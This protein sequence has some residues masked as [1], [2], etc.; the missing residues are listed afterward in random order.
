MEGTL[1]AGLVEGVD[2]VALPKSV[3]KALHFRYSGAPVFP[4]VLLRLDP[5]GGGEGTGTGVSGGEAGGEGGGGDEF[6]IRSR[7]VGGHA[8]PRRNVGDGIGP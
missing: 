1:R 5:E 4:R 6:V 3:W 8:A 7:G 2:F